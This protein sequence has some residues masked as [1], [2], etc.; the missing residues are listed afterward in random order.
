MFVGKSGAYPKNGS[1]V[2]NVIKL[3]KVVSYDFSQLARAFV[4]VTYGRKKF[5]NI[6]PWKFFDSGGPLPL[7]KIL[8]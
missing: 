6:G 1:P 2:A 7:L 4:V 5:Y 3:F 8:D